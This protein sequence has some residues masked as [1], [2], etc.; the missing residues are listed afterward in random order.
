MILGERP[1]TRIAEMILPI[2]GSWGPKSGFENANVIDT[3][4]IFNRPQYIASAWCKTIVT[5]YIK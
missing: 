5:S 2:T 1:S 3:L 4:C